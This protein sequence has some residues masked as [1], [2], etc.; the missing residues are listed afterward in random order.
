MNLQEL[1]GI[2]EKYRNKSEKMY[3]SHSCPLKIAKRSLK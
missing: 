2:I 1:E 3:P